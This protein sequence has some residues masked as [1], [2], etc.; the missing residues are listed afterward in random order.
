MEIEEEYDSVGIYIHLDKLSSDLVKYKS[1]IH[2]LTL[3]SNK[4]LDII[5]HCNEIIENLNDIH[6][7]KKWNE[8][9]KL[10]SSFYVMTSQKTYQCGKILL[11]VNVIFE[12]WCDY[13]IFIEDSWDMLVITNGIFINNLHII[14]IYIYNN[15]YIKILLII[16]LFIYLFFLIN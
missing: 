6:L 7:W 5:I 12:K 11:D 9:E 15:L 10:L 2:H 3:K 8:I 14:Y 13:D 4:R 1:T 16:Y